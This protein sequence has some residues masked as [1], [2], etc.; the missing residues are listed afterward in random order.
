MSSSSIVSSIVAR[1]ASSAA[2]LRCSCSAG[3]KTSGAEAPFPLLAASVA[4][5]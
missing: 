4:I 5:S 3:D 1:W 2:C